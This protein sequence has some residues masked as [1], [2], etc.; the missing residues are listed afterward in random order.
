LGEIFLLISSFLN[1]RKYLVKPEFFSKCDFIE[2]SDFATS[3]K[4]LV[5]ENC[6]EDG[7]AMCQNQC[8]NAVP[9]LLDHSDLMFGKTLRGRYQIIRQLGSGGFSTTFVAKDLDLPGQP[10][11]VVKQLKSKDS[12]PSILQT[13]RRLFD[14]EAQVLYRLGKHEQIPQLY[15]HFAEN[16]EFY[17]VQE[18]VEGEDLAQQ[19]FSE[20]KWNES[21]VITFLRDVLQILA[22]V[23]QQDVIHRD[24]KPSNL[25]RRQQDGKV[26]LID[27]G[28]VK[29]IKTL[30][31]HSGNQ[32]TGTILIGSSGYMP[33]EQLKG[34]PRFNSDIYAVGVTAIQLLT[35]IS[36]EQ[37]EE[38]QETG[39]IIWRKQASVSNELAII[40]EKMVRSHFRERY[41]SVKEVIFDLEKLENYTSY[42][43]QI[44]K[45]AK[46]PNIYIKKYFYLLV[47]LLTGGF[48][49]T[50][51]NLWNFITSQNLVMSQQEI[52]AKPTFKSLDSEA[53]RLLEQGK[54][55][56]ELQ[57]YEEAV[58]VLDRTLQ[59]DPKYPE[60]WLKRGQALSKLQKHEEALNSFEEALKIQAEYSQAWYERG[61]VLEQLNREELAQESLVKALEIQPNYAEAWYKLGDIKTKQK[62]YKEA[63]LSLSKATEIKP[64]YSNAWYKMG[65]LLNKLNQQKEA[66]IALNKAL[67][68][69]INNV[70]AW[71]E[72]GST[73]AKLKQ[74]EEALDS[75]DKAV[76]I[77][78]ESAEAWQKRGQ[79][80]GELKRHD[81]AIASLDKAIQIKQDYADAWYE[82]GI[83]LG[84]LNNDEE[85]IASLDR[86]IQIKSDYAEAWYYRGLILEKK[87][88]LNEAIEAYNKT[89]QIWPANQEAIAK[90]KRLQK[91][92]GR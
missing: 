88:Q 21:Q 10:L 11:C 91:R 47:V 75:F 77:N 17:L 56:I 12:E 1:L 87:Q 46:T 7:V 49:L 36:P 16:Q 53:V 9:V 68:L 64:D 41:Q 8:N 45:S 81:E 58:A 90:R 65:V 52:V 62:K 2:E 61:L 70:E 34:K 71:V 82:R 60:A 29:E 20:K 25:I 85:A 13:I 32:M 22:F 15:A 66:L 89:I 37:F 4:D 86:A 79:I 40:L 57:R 33:T 35:G 6:A 83:I 18:Y 55:L 39:E 5:T 27:F 92:L 73:L 74:N 31:L 67:E 54:V 72:H 23:H 50:V 26:V 44:L 43:T 14:T 69:E 76:K 19:L 38:D 80:L 42:E 28:A 51:A 84:K 78:P 48:S 24:I 59:I 63:Y 30:V 3:K